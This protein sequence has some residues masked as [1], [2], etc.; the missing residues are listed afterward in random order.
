MHNLKPTAASSLSLPPDSYI[1]SIDASGSGSFAAIS[2]DDSLRVFDAGSL[3]LVSLVSA[4]THDGGVTSLRTYRAGDHPLLTTAG[5]DG[6]VKLWDLRTGNSSA[7]GNLQMRESVLCFRF[8]CVPSRRCQL[9]AGLHVC[10]SHWCL[11]T[12]HSR[13]QSSCPFCRLLPRD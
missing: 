7:V 13:A 6:L 10:I 12:A 11:L 4:K 5:R 2:S 1:Y 3:G 8:L 9:V